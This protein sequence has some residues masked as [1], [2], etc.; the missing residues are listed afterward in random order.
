MS[1][2]SRSRNWEWTDV[3]LVAGVRKP[4][5][6][7]GRDRYLKGDERERLLAACASSTS[8]DLYAIVIIAMSTGMR[9]G[10]IT[11]LQWSD[12]D[13]IAGFVSLSQT[14]NGERRAVPLVGPAL[15][16]LKARVIQ[17][18]GESALVFPGTTNTGR[19]IDIRTPWETALR[20]ASISNFRFHDLRHSAASYM[21]DEWCFP[22]RHRGSAGSQ[23]TADGTPLLASIFATSQRRRGEDESAG[24]WRYLILRPRR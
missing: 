14:K 9:Q 18:N 2:Q 10:E 19:P 11:S 22:P 12:V 15:H 21:G 16:A 5:E 20:R 24:V 17:L 7:R 13:L 6:P 8:A 3:N 4:R 23:D 1:S